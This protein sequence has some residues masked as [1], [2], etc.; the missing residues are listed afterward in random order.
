MII[1]T[2]VMFLM[3]QVVM[4]TSEFIVE[5]YFLCFPTVLLQN[6]HARRAAGNR[7][8]SSTSESLRQTCYLFQ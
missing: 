8:P 3:K 6:L 2:N 7:G 5:Q 4:L 1:L